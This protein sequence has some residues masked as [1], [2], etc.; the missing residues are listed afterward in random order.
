MY[1]NYNQN[2]QQMLQKEK[3]DNTNIHNFVKI[4]INQVF[5]LDSDDDEWLK[6]TIR[7]RLVL[8]EKRPIEKVERGKSVDRFVEKEHC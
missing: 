6:T 1:N 8:E 7:D 3:A 2:D 5:E 4:S